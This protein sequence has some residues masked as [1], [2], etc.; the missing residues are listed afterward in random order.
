MMKEDSPPTALPRHARN[1]NEQRRGVSTREGG[2]NVRSHPWHLCMRARHERPHRAFR[3]IDRLR[4]IRL[5]PRPPLRSHHKKCRLA[6][7]LSPATARPLCLTDAA[8]STAAVAATLCHHVCCFAS[9]HQQT[10]ATT[11]ALPALPITGHRHI[12]VIPVIPHHCAGRHDRHDHLPASQP[13]SN[14]YQILPPSKHARAT[15][16]PCHTTCILAKWAPP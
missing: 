12:A 1:T 8:T 2:T 13:C 4:P 6:P 11:A 5:L 3:N 7:F 16:P 14:H 15:N 9:C 10:H